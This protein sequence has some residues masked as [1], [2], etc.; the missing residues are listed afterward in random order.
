MISLGERIS[1]AFLVLTI[2]FFALGIFFGFYDGII[3]APYLSFAY[4]MTFL[5]FLVVP[6]LIVW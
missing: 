5:V 4:G 2:I 3:I 6:S 1:K